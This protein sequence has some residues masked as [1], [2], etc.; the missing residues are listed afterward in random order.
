MSHRVIIAFC[1]PIGSGKTTAANYLVDEY[2]FRRIRFAG[3]LKAMLRALGLS[4]REVDGDLKEVACDLLGGRTPRHAMQT[5]GTEWGRQMICGDLWTR[6]WVK[7]VEMVPEGVGIAVD[8][9]RFPNEAAIMRSLSPASLVIK[10]KRRGTGGSKTDHVSELS[11]FPFNVELENDGDTFALY[12]K[13]DNLLRP[14]AY[15]FK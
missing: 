1:G 4:E 6:A 11:T 2:N 14:K 13:I 9:L 8:D 15:P 7:A 10:L 12:D 5:L 3:P